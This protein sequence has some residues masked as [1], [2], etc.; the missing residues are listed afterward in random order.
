MFLP[1]L[2][3][4]IRGV[5]GRDIHGRHELGPETPC[6]FGSVSLKTGAKKT[7]VR[8]DSSASRGAANETAV[9]RGRILIPASITVK[10]GDIFSFQGQRYEVVAAHSRF[11]VTG[12]F[13][14]W[15]VD[16]ETFL[17]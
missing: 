1:N 10:N 14:H 12:A 2:V 16:L 15:E 17:G 13:D 8:A 9:E 4:T 5:I 6:P 11:A 3:G 7:T